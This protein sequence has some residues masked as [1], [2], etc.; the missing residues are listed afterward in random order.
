M[1]SFNEVKVLDGLCIGI[2]LLAVWYRTRGEA[3]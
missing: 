1:E 3:M 2:Y